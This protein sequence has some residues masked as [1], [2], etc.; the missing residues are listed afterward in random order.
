MMILAIVVA[1]EGGAEP[2]SL[3]RAQ[4][5]G[6]RVHAAVDA[7]RRTEQTTINDQVR[8]CEVP[9][10]PFGERARAAVVRD[11]LQ[12]TGLKNVRFDRAGN[13]VGERIGRHARPNVVLTAHLDTVFPEGTRVTVRREGASLRGPGIGD[14]CR[15]LAVFVAVARALTAGDVHTAGSITLAATGGDEGL[16]DLR[17]VRTLLGETLK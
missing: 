16:G 14:N 17:W 4:S 1:A 8:L 7:A 15:G 10:P 13:V 12:A 9:A 2:R 3:S 11:M 5:P 6:V